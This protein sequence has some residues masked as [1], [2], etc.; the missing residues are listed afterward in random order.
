MNVEEHAYKALEEHAYE[1]LCCLQG[2][3]ERETVTATVEGV[4][5]G[6]QEGHCGRNHSKSQRVVSSTVGT[7]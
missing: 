6:A 3:V 4:P 7:E 5:G 1:A 2:Q